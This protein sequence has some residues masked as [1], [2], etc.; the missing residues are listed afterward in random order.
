M[1]ARAAMVYLGW[2]GYLVLCW[3]VLPGNWKEGTQLRDGTKLKYKMN[4]LP[5]FTATVIASLVVYFVYGH[6]PFLFLSKHCYGLMFSAFLMSTVQALFVY[7]RSHFNGEMLA[8]EGNT[9]SVP[10]DFFIGRPL[11][12]RLG[13]FDVKS[14]NELRPGMMLWF[15]LNLGYMAQMK[16]DYGYITD[17]MWIV[18]LA[19]G[20][21]TADSLWNESAVLTTM[22]ITSD[23]FGFMLSFGTMCWIP[24]TFSLQARYLSAHGATLGSLVSTLI[25]GFNALGYY[26][27]R[28]S[29]G[30]KDNFR[31]GRI[32][33]LKYMETERGTKLITSGWWGRSRHPN[34]MGD[35]FMALSWSL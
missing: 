10:Y 21:Y 31:N 28:A 34:Y 20:F 2:Y 25:L 30:E 6:E 5:T 24:F 12:P 13:M 18:V 23:G 4:A 3:F 35:L 32:G 11:N 22:D 1:D 16:E 15:M 19:Q 7:T 33:N 27:F 14:F 29:N 8:L 26:I 9:G 17:S